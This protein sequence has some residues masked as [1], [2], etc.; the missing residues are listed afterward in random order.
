MCARHRA[1]TR[2]PCRKMVGHAMVHAEVENQFTRSTSMRIHAI[3]RLLTSFHDRC[4]AGVRLPA[5]GADSRARSSP[6]N[7]KTARNRSCRARRVSRRSAPSHA[8]F[9]VGDIEDVVVHPP[10]TDLERLGR[11]N[12]RHRSP[13]CRCL[14][15]SG[16]HQAVSGARYTTGRLSKSSS[17]VWR[18]DL[19]T[20]AASDR[21]AGAHARLREYQR[22]RERAEADTHVAE[23][24]TSLVYPPPRDPAT[25]FVQARR[26]VSKADLAENSSV[27]ACT[28]PRRRRPRSAVWSTIRTRTPTASAKAARGPSALADDQDVGSRIDGVFIVQGRF[29]TPGAETVT[30]GVGEHQANCFAIRTNKSSG[31]DP[32]PVINEKTASQSAH[33]GG[34][35]GGAGPGE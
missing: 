14:A 22:I 11:G 6:F 7:G 16:A 28:A 35:A 29:H 4:R 13:Q 34:G 23:G 18:F 32:D 12:A 9:H 15:R 17:S 33:S 25:A 19:D 8:R 24:E 2:H 10:K 30:I 26:R 31:I 1:G 20:A 27:R 21:S 3:T 5:H